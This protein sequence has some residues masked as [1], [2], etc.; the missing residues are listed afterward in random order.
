MPAHSTPRHL[1]AELAQRFVLD[2]AA[3]PSSLFQE[4]ASETE[5]RI[6]RII[7]ALGCMLYFV[8]MVV[9]PLPFGIESGPIDVF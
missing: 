5:E 4:V 3:L 8:N 7:T 2:P 9:L 6:V 1:S